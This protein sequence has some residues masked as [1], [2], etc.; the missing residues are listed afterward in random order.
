[1][2]LEI[3]DNQILNIIKNRMPK[4]ALEDFN[5]N[6]KPSNIISKVNNIKYLV[7][8][9]I[10]R[11]ST[12]WFT[13]YEDKL[14]CILNILGTNNYYLVD[15]IFDKELVY[16]NCYIFGYLFYKNN[17]SIFSLDKVLNYN[18][19]YELNNFNA[20]NDE[21]LTKNFE[22]KLNYFKYILN[23]IDSKGKNI[24]FCLPIILDIQKIK[25][26][27]K[28]IT[29][30]IENSK[31][32]CNNIQKLYNIYSISIFDKFK[33]YNN[34]GLE[35]LEKILLNSLCINNNFNNNNFN[36]NNFNNNNFNNNNLR[37]INKSAINKYN[38][39]IVNEVYF[40]IKAGLGQDEYYIFL[41]NEFYANLLIDSYKLS[42]L[43]NS[44]YRDIKENKNLDYLEESDDEEEFNNNS[45]SKYTNLDKLIIFK[46]KFNKKFK[47]W[48]PVDCNNYSSTSSIDEVKYIEKNL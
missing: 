10:G 29:S 4:F 26:L 16:N 38:P 14:L 41:N 1:M 47:K 37:S 19:F 44:Y 5:N 8:N 32:N 39:N 24:I 43:M 25:Y 20:N 11:K 23:N 48:I 18:K 15:N 40:N 27:Y 7:F 21:N 42:V 6:Y 28:T 34:Y 2:K 35:N 12:I 9:P 30:D 31:Y 36:N 22:K 33:R 13:Y 3:L 17:K 45:I 46:C